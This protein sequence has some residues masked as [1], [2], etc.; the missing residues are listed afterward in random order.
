M[1]TKIAKAAKRLKMKDLE[2]ATGVGRETIR[3]YIR[4]GLLPAPD[5]P[6]KNVAWYD[7]SFVERILVV[8]K[9][10]TER[11]LPLA[12]IK[13]LVSSDDAPAKAEV[14]TLLDLDRTLTPATRDRSARPPERL[15]VLAKR[16]GLSAKEILA[17]AKT[18]AIAVV[19][20]GGDQWLE[21][22]DIALV[23][24]WANARRAGYTEDVGFSAD[25]LRMYVDFSRWIVREEL[26]NFTSRVTG[27]VDSERLKRM[28]EV[29]IPNSGE[30][31]RLIHER[32]MLDAIARGNVPQPAVSPDDAEAA[33]D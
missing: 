15:S 4:E 19:T 11:Y 32:V 27:K 18:E 30:I 29:G 23:E 28:A 20:R 5:R 6:A 2:R 17:M 16:V 25:T 10:Q 21:G 22:R 14:E 7:E 12:V 3:F 31:L 8:K 1:S 24:L 33:N 9:L 13:S 26:R